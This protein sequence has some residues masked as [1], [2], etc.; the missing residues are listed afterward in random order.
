MFIQ[1]GTV[2]ASYST[3]KYI[4]RPL[5]LQPPYR[6]HF[7]C[8]LQAGQKNCIFNWGTHIIFYGWW[9]PMGG[10]SAMS[11]I[12]EK[13]WKNWC[14]FFLF[15]PIL[16]IFDRNSTYRVR[17]NLVIFSAL[18]CQTFFQHI[19]DSSTIQ[20]KVHDLACYLSYRDT[21]LKVVQ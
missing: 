3:L 2:W 8:T 13:S 14:Q 15:G 11:E 16:S 1:W 9:I 6:Q 7:K 12:R 10:C 20:Y 5:S 4:Y 17:K 19:G 21:K 18:S